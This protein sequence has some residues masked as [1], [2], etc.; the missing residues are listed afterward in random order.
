MASFS[1]FSNI[2]P[3]PVHKIGTVGQT[4]VTG[5]TGP[6]FSSIKL[7]SIDSLMSDKTNSKRIN[8]RA[9][10][11]HK[12]EIDISYNP[13]TR[14]EFDPVYT[15]LMHRRTILKPFYVELPQ[16]VGQSSSATVVNGEFLKGV[17]KLIVTNPT[18]GTVPPMILKIGTESKVYMITRVE[19]TTSYNS[20]L[21][22]LLADEERFH[23]TP[24]LV[25]NVTNNEALDFI[26][27]W[28]YV[29]EV[30]DTL[31]Y[32]IDDKNLYKFSLKL[33]EVNI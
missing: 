29:Q 25:H 21:P 15:F 5:S 14:E 11:Y 8:T 32:T 28:F 19:S 3:D 24:G 2:L 23:I 12:W 30:G 4:D 7:S 33:E 17:D 10:S 6:G 16:Y 22:T 20:I 27:P 18:P 9:V 31:S 13:M 1:D 26:T